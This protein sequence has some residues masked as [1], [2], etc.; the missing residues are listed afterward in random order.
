MI[1]RVPRETARNMAF[2]V[3]YNTEWIVT[4]EK[5]DPKAS[6]RKLRQQVQL[7]ATSSFA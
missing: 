6:K 7:Y 3:I 5:R 4:Q 2:E 1:L